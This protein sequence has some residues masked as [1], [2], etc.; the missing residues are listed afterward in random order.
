MVE[1]KTDLNQCPFISNSGCVLPRDAMTPLCRLYICRE[2]AIFAPAKIEEK[3]DQYFS[4]QE[5][6]LNIYLNKRLI[7]DQSLTSSELNDFI[8]ESAQTINTMIAGINRSNLSIE[9]F[10]REINIEHFGRLP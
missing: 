2:A 4:S 6:D 10:Q 1:M 7:Y 3:F 8:A 5:Y 9:T